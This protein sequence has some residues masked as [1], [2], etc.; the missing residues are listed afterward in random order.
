[1]SECGFLFAQFERHLKK[2]PQFVNVLF[3]IVVKYVIIVNKKLLLFLIQN[4][5]LDHHILC[6]YFN[7]T[8]G[9]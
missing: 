5:Y 1:M 4:Y 7:S 9:L 3:V 6:L 8:G 2:I